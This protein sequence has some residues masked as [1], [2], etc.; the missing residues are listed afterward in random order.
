MFSHA[1]SAWVDSHSFLK[2][3]A[4]H[5][6][7]LTKPGLIAVTYSKLTSATPLPWKSAGLK[8]FSVEL[9]LHTV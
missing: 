1:D 3:S 4:E 9:A 5:E 8:V 7:D 2:R 6:L